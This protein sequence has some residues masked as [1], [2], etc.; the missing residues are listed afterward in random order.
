MG[1]KH[2]Q[3]LIKYEVIQMLNYKVLL[4]YFS[5]NPAMFSYQLP[6]RLISLPILSTDEKRSFG[7]GRFK[8]ETMM[9]IK[10]III[11]VLVTHNSFGLSLV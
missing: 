10:Q 1:I 6:A 3:I 4:F 7:S 5:F 8:H 11:K 9:Q 2:F